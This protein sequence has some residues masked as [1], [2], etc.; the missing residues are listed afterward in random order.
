[1]RTSDAFVGLDCVDC[2]SRHDPST[3]AGRCPEC[4]GILDPAYDL[5]RVTVTRNE[6][7]SRPGVSMWRY[8]EMLPFPRE[9]AI[10]LCEGM[11]PL[12]ECPPLAESIGVGRV[13]IK[14]ERSNS[15]GTFKD[16]GQSAAM[17]GAVQMGADSVSIPSAGNAGHAMAAY[18][19]RAGL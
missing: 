1:M 7:E 3:V 8:D 13:L 6:W 2:E 15:I 14:D 16:R 11:T 18:A 10:S 12:L 5:N 4:D 17:T 19:A 9:S